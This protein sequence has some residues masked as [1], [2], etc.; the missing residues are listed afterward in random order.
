MRDR[1]YHHGDLHEALVNAGVEAA[2]TS[3][4]SAVSIRLLAK[5]VGVSPT[6]AYRHFPSLEHLTAAVSQRAR[7]QL[8]RAMRAAMDGV[9][10]DDPPARAWDRLLASGRAYVRFAVAEPH[11]FAMAFAPCEAPPPRP[12]EPDA[13]ALLVGAL[14]DVASTGGLAPLPPMA[15]PVAAWATVHGLA[16]LVTGTTLPADVN[17]DAVTDAVLGV[18]LRGLGA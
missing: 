4:P 7:E 14:D 5:D 2:R 16:G 1:P 11:L 13:W 3:G 12:D 6:A 18:L 8:A 9:A 15:A 10:T 17:P